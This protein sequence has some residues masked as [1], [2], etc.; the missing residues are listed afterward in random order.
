[1]STQRLRPQTKGTL[2]RTSTSRIERNVR[3]Q[4]EWHVIAPHVQIAMIYIRH[5]WQGI[6]ILNLWSIGV[7]NHRA[8]LAVRNAENFLQRLAL[9]ELDHRIVKFFAAN[10]INRRAIL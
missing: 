3:M 2:R 10:K 1:M 9:R 6:E 4:Q 5:M 8:I 7:M